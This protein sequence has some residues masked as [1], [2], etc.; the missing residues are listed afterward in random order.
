MVDKFQVI[1]LR[2][3]YRTIDLLPKKWNILGSN[4]IEGIVTTDDRI[5]DIINGSVPVTHDELKI[6]GYKDALIFWGM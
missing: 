3:K 4:A 1:Y 5:R 2:V 6:S